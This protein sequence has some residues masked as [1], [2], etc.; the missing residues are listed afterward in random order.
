MSE[1]VKEI[2]EKPESSDSE[3][4]VKPKKEKKK[5]VNSH[6]HMKGE[7]IACPTEETIFEILKIDKKYLDPINRNLEDNVTS[8]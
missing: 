3:I 8:L 7:K 5:V 2:E 1:I 6:Q 4:E